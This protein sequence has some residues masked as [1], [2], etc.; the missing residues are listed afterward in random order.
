V[1]LANDV[2]FDAEMSQALG[3]ASMDELLGGGREDETPFEPE[4]LQS[5]RVW[6][7]DATMCL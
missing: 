4:S 3:G 5:G 1:P 6:P 2:D 7:S